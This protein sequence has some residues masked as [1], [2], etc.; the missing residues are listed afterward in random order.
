[1]ASTTQQGHSMKIQAYQEKESYF[2]RALPLEYLN[3]TPEGHG[4]D[5]PKSCVNN[6]NKNELNNLKSSLNND[7][8]VQSLQ[9]RKLFIQTVLTLLSFR[10]TMSFGSSRATV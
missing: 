6:A 5:K 3:S 8:T 2:V 1:M 4:M 10:K 7:Y 9:K